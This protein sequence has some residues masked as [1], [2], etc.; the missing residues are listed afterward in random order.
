[1]TLDTTRW[2]AAHGQKPSGF[3]LWE[4]LT[5]TAGRRILI[6]TDGPW[7]KTRDRVLRALKD[8]Y[9]PKLTVELLP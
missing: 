7:A 3:H 2:E 9:G 4:F 6:S 1:M 8:T 5:H